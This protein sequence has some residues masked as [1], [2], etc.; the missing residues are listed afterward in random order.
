MDKEKTL[1]Q[2]G[3]NLKESRIKAGKTQEQL[4][5]FLD[6]DRAH[7]SRLETGK[8]NPSFF[9]LCKIAEYLK[10]KLEEVIKGI[11]L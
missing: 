11:K 9:T 1:M 2:L 5:E 6:F 3:K 4:A 8:R 10:V 7:I